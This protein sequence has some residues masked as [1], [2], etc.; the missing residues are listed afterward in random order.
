MKRLIF[1]LPILLILSGCLTREEYS[2]KF[3]YKNGRVEKIHHNVCSKKG[4]DEKDY[5]P[6][7][8]WALLKETIKEIRE[9]YDKDVIESV[10]TEL[11]Q[12][13]DTLSAKEIYKVKCPKCFPSKTAIL[14]ML[15]DD[16][17]WR[18]EIINKEIF[19]FVPPGKSILNSNGQNIVTE[20]NNIIIWPEDQEAFEYTVKESTAGGESLLPFYLKEKGGGAVIK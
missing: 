20:H 16:E 1:I 10:S 8:D 12:E 4:F 6:E 7:K 19:A 11:F 5:S 9:K 17:K 15:H 2:F 14:S 13:G 18:F 3:N